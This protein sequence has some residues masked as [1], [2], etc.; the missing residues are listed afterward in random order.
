[1]RLCVVVCW[2]PLMV[3]CVCCLLLLFGV[4][5]Y[6]LLQFVVVVCLSVVLPAGACSCSLL[7]VVG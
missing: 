1:M 5:C 6:C 2:Y 4:V 3:M 7:Y